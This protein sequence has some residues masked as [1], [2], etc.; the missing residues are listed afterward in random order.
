MSRP[1]SREPDGR[2]ARVLRR[3]AVWSLGIAVLL[4]AW[5]VVGATLTDRGIQA[6]FVHTAEEGDW[7][8][9]RLFSAR[10]VSAHFADAVE[11]VRPGSTSD[12]GEVTWRASGN[13]LVI[14]LDGILTVSDRDVGPGA[15]TVTID[16]VT[17]DVS[18]R[19]PINY[20][21]T[22]G[23]NFVVGLS[24]RNTMLVE[25]PENLETASATLRIRMGY[26]DDRADSLLVL[27]FSLEGA[28]RETLTQ[29]RGATWSVQ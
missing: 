23:A 24:R 10:V 15:A 8:E 17:Y 1:A 20:R 28:P 22:T 5:L 13:W 11:T 2:G 26:G 25:L 19:P 14:T 18:T 12:P 6:P 7:A 29:V 9:G 3:S 4:V 16:G 21:S 27:P